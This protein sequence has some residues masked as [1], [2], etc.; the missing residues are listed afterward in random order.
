MDLTTRELGAIP[1]NLLSSAFTYA[2]MA[3]SDLYVIYRTVSIL[4][5]LVKSK[6]VSTAENPGMSVEAI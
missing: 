1:G 5:L 2:A 6:L 3:G 4:F